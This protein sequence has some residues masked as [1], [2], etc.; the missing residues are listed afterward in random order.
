M[1]LADQLR[2]DSRYKQATQAPAPA[3]VLTDNL[4]LLPT[5]GKALDL[6]C[7]LGGNALWLAER[8]L[9]VEAWDCSAVALEKLQQ[10][11]GQRSLEITTRVADLDDTL[12][13]AASFDLIVVSSFLNR[14]LCPAIANALRPGGILAYQTFTQ[15]QAVS[16]LG[17]PSNPAFLLAPGELLCLFADLA[18]CVYREERDCG[19]LQQGLRNQAYLLATRGRN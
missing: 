17:G 18:P 10:M 2:W 4:H 7:G 5:S 12:P 14:T 8:G 13:E 6:A 15:A 3:A 11:A 16:G 9:T 1:S 19:D